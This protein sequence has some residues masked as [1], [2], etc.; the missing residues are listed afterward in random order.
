MK[1]FYKYKGKIV[2][3]S[4]LH[5]I[6]KQEKIVRSK[7]FD[8]PETFKMPT[9]NN[10]SSLDEFFKGKQEHL[11]TMYGLTDSQK[12]KKIRMNIDQMRIDGKSLILSFGG[13]VI[14]FSKVPMDKW[15]EAINDA[16]IA[17]RDKNGVETKTKLIQFLNGKKLDMETFKSIFK[18][19]VFTHEDLNELKTLMRYQKGTVYKS[20]QSMVMDNEISLDLNLLGEYNPIVA[21][22]YD[23]DGT[24]FLD[25]FDVTR[26]MFTSVDQSSK[27]GMSI[28]GN[29]VNS[30]Y[31]LRN[32]VG[33]SN[34][35]VSR[36]TA[37]LNLV[38]N[39]IAA[40]NYNVV[41]KDAT[42]IKMSSYA[43]GNEAKVQAHSIDHVYA[44]QNLRNI[45]RFEDISEN[46]NPDL[47]A[48]FM[49][50]NVPNNEFNYVKFLID[51]YR[52]NEDVYEKSDPNRYGIK[53][54][55]EALSEYESNVLDKNELVGLIEA[56]LSKLHKI[57]LED[58]NAIHDIKTEHQMLME[59]YRSAS[60]LSKMSH[61]LNSFSDIKFMDKNLMNNSSISQE[62]VQEAREILDRSS[63]KI[64][65]KMQSINKDFDKK[66]FQ[67]Y[68][69][70]F[71]SQKG[72]TSII[73]NEN[74]LFY[75]PA[76]ATVK[77]INGNERKAGY[78][79]WTTDSKQDRI[80]AEQA[81]AKLS[82][83]TITQD[84]LDAN[85]WMVE[86]ITDRY[87]RMIMHQ[88]QMNYGNY[89]NYTT[90][91]GMNEKEAYEFAKNELFTKYHYREGMIP[92]I[93][94]RISERLYAGEVGKGIKRSIDN[95]TSEDDL[96]Y[97]LPIN[98]N[99]SKYF[100]D[101]IEDIFM[102]QIGRSTS[103]EK[104]SRLGQT[105]FMNKIGLREMVN[106]EGEYYYDTV[107][108]DGAMNDGFTMDMQTAF[109]SFML[110]GERKMEYEQHALPYLNGLY[111]ELE[112][113]K[114]LKGQN[115]DSLTEYLSDYL[116]Q[117]VVN[118]R[119]K[120]KGLSDKTEKTIGMATK[121]TTARTMFANMNI[122]QIS[123]FQNFANAVTEAVASDMVGHFQFGKKEMLE[124]SAKFFSDYGKM[125]ELAAR[126]QIVNASEM[127]SI[128][129]FYKGYKG[130]KQLL[131]TFM[132]SL[133]NWATDFYARVVVMAAQMMKDGTY[134]AY[135][136][137]EEGNLSF[138]EN[139]VDFFEGEE[140]KARKEYV[141]QRILLEGGTLNSDGSLPDAYINQEKVNLKWIS[142][143]YIIGGYDPIESATIGNTVLA[144][145]F[146]TFRT[147]MLAKLGVIYKEKS[148]QDKGGRL[149][150]IKDENGNYTGQWERRITEGW[151]NTWGR[152]ILDGVRLGSKSPSAWSKMTP[153]E[154]MNLARGGVTMSMF[155]L[156]WMLAE[157]LIDDDDD[158]PLD[159]VDKKT[160]KMKPIPGI[161]FYNNFKYSLSSL[162]LVEDIWQFFKSPFMTINIINRF[163]HSM[164]GDFDV[165]K[166][167]DIPG[168]HKNFLTPF[169][170]IWFTFDADSMRERQ[171]ELREQEKEERR[172]KRKE[173]KQIENDTN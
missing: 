78:I 102:E 37:L 104:Y 103:V 153:D 92:I 159:L 128:T 165:Q 24:M 10:L 18:T 55:R 139:K 4:D 44:K 106:N 5:N 22:H 138:D 35:F 43:K 173:Q 160:G 151:V 95:I 45:V 62:Q 56:R 46:M 172:Q 155:A 97:I 89:F 167:L 115:A 11:Q 38:T 111:V 52:N 27:K 133:P 101:N 149:V 2:E 34:D 171:L 53:K 81:K 108:I 150:M 126:F 169:E 88:L 66:V 72:N 20:L 73:R 125:T 47:K 7:K 63:H 1:C 147:W 79:L 59:L 85:K 94:K 156:M 144:K 112:M 161:R 116:R 83:G 105:N 142:D 6:I 90:K 134:D 127:E 25:L 50:D 19:D 17:P 99:E 109:K 136:M 76:M 170:A 13:N 152:F 93:P 122:A 137:D 28:L 69:S 130:N 60:L 8:I 36:S 68:R 23:K 168:I 58:G 129:H 163:T 110:I 140:G 118:E 107:D 135:T 71:T 154:K 64:V 75:E 39:M 16:F 31:A 123:A 82:N 143:K 70:Y 157:A 121:L 145:Q 26:S 32:G 117:T 119:K 98:E 74:F 42:L 21:I 114:Q 91:K 100:V 86:Q 148:F 84:L 33:L 9:L 77:D 29:L 120:V 30:S 15:D 57:G 146:K 113:N 54:M 65:S 132:A 158:D 49:M 67:K 124:A 12:L 40:N 166:M 141:K 41:I 87:V 80:F 131:S 14:D 61:Q 3:K 164:L 96:S 51:F 162:I 48:Y